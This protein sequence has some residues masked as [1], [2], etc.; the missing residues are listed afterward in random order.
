MQA[1]PTGSWLQTALPTSPA[2][3]SCSFLLVPSSSQSATEPRSSIS[4]KNKEEFSSTWELHRSGQRWL[5]LPLIFTA[6]TPAP[7][8]PYWPFQ[9]Q[10]R[11]NATAKWHFLSPAVQVAPAVTAHFPRGSPSSFPFCPPEV[12]LAPSSSS[13]LVINLQL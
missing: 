5:F 10:G 6:L 9:K 4:T 2:S 8:P 7:R 3:Q 11:L 13:R 12:C 1:L